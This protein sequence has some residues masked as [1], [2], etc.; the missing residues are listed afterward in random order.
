[1]L[2]YLNLL[3]LT[4]LGHVIVR[5]NSYNYLKLILCLLLFQFDRTYFSIHDD[6]LIVG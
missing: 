2:R 4:N 3:G 1:M 6:T 5:D